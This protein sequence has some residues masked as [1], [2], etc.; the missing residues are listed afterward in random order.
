MLSFPGLLYSATESKK[1][2]DTNTSIY[3]LLLTNV[4][5]LLPCKD[6]TMEK[7]EPFAICC[8]QMA[9]ILCR[10]QI[11]C[12]YTMTQI[13]TCYVCKFLTQNLYFI[14]CRYN[15]VFLVLTYGIPMMVMVVCYTLMG[16]E[17]WGSQSIGE[18]TERQRESVKS[19]KKVLF[20]V[21]LSVQQN[22]W[23]IIFFELICVFRLYGC[24]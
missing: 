21:T 6:I 16:K 17:L 13:L 20:V 9:S 15:I 7:L 18:H 22:K 23:N 11:T 14:Y 1:Y 24:L 10:L 2:T 19:K 5:T 3:F 4:F 8:G 12:K